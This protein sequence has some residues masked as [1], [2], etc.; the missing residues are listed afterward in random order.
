M[1]PYEET[2]HFLPSEAVRRRIP[3]SSILRL[4]R[5]RRPSL[6]EVAPEVRQPTAASLRQTRTTTEGT[7]G[8]LLPC[9]VPNAAR[10]GGV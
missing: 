8:V 6:Q 1:Q 9:P 3:P 2:D 7:C 4:S 5:P 10:M